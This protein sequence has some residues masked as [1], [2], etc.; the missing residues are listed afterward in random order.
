MMRLAPNN[1]VLNVVVVYDIGPPSGV[2]A[3]QNAIHSV[4]HDLTKLLF[5]RLTATLTQ[6]DAF[7]FDHCS[8]SSD[9]ATL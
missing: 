9:F 2:R 3:L 5:S 1:N 6:A 7:W 4:S 8:P